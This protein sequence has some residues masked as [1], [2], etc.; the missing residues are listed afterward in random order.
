ME[1]LQALFTMHE[2]L[3]MLADSTIKNHIVVEPDPNTSTPTEKHII[4]IKHELADDIIEKIEPLL[5]KRNLKIKKTEDSF[6][7]H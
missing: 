5:E 4:K 7:I 3:V 2:L 1:K 6:M